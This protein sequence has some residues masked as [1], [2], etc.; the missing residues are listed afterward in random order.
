VVTGGSGSDALRSRVVN[1]DERYLEELRAEFPRLRVIEKA[2]SPFS[3]LIDIALRIVTLGGQRHFLTRYVTT[4]GTTIYLPEG[5][6]RRSPESRYVTLRH[7]AVHLRQFRRY[8]LVGTA[9]LYLLPVLPL[10]LAYGRARLEWEAYAET[11]RATREVFGRDAAHD[12]E[13][14]THIVRQFTGPAY[15]WMWPFPCVVR[16]WIDRALGE[17]EVERAEGG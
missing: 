2:R 3:R 12:H 4:I 15:G 16:R 8:G 6:E 14:H 7:E 9:L 11:L 10:G 1:L 5:W 17:L 13:L